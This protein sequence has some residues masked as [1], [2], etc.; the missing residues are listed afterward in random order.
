M[1][2]TFRFRW[3]KRAYLQK[4]GEHVEL[5]LFLICECK[6]HSGMVIHSLHDDY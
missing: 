4:T 2:C 6:K 1:N 3:S 5:G